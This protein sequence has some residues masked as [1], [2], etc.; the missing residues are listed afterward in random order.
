MRGWPPRDATKAVAFAAVLVLLAGQV[1]VAADESRIAARAA[2]DQRIVAQL[3]EGERVL[4]LRT[5]LER[6]RDRL[7]AHLR[8][9][10]YGGERSAVVARFVRDAAR[11]AARERTAITTMTAVGVPGSVAAMPVAPTT[12]ATTAVADEFET[13]PLDLTVEGRY[14]DV[15]ST[16]RA[17]STTRVPATVEVTSLARKQA[18]S[19]DATLS[20]QLRVTI[21]RMVFPRPAQPV[22]AQRSTLPLNRTDAGARP[23]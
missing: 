9:V 20:A 13:V 21:E 11:I 17:L 6:E 8:A 14:A 3:A 5:G 22:G 15:L 7:R 18:G 1:V 23:A 10:D 16:V 19:S 4:R 12:P 2:E